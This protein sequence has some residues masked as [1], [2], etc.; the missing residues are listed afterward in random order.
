M[1]MA[2]KELRRYSW[3]R[4]W[5]RS[6]LRLCFYHDHDLRQDPDPK[7][8][9][10]SDPK[11]DS[12]PDPKPDP[13]QNPEHD[14]DSRTQKPL[15]IIPETDSDPDPDPDHCPDPNHDLGVVFLFD[16][17]S[18]LLKA[19]FR[20]LHRRQTI[21]IHLICNRE[22]KIQIKQTRIGSDFQTYPVHTNHKM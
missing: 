21:S 18:K 4:S 20:E 3:S 12:K 7:L 11:P 16:L 2:K 5:Q 22:Q 9:S 19:I 8:D 15:S 17:E 13:G 1:T 6:Q 10:K 14:P